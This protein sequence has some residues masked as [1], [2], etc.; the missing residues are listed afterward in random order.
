MSNYNFRDTYRNQTRT[1]T[2]LFEQAK[3][4]PEA[5]LLIAAGAALLLGQRTSLGSVASSYLDKGRNLAS[6]TAG[7]IGAKVG[8]RASQVGETIK[9]AR[10]TAVSYASD[11]ADRATTYATD[12]KDKLVDK[13]TDAK[14]K[15][16]EKAGEAK[17][18]IVEKAQTYYDE[19]PRQISTRFEDMAENQPLMLAGLG[20][21]AGAAIGYA[22]PATRVEARTFANAGEQLNAASQQALETAKAAANEAGKSLLSAAEERGLTKEGL[23]DVARDAL[24]AATAQ[25]EKAVGGSTFASGSAPKPIGGQ[26][27]GAAPISSTQNNKPGSTGGA[28]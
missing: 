15:L 12:T 24:G 18:L 19:V 8:D 22:L 1:G 14:D 4:R 28:R 27:G 13:A 2:G 3:Q 17:D 23:K 21:L 16:V 25:A 11:A 26:S 6:D 20:V 10:D 9:D 5:L 7:T